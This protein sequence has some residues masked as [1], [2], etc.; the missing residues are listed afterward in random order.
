MEQK[1]TEKREKD[2]SLVVFLLK[3]TPVLVPPD[4]KNWNIPNLYSSYFHSENIMNRFNYYRF[5]SID[6]I[7]R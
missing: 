3:N 4:K 5:I 6:D 2:H 1:E 7:T